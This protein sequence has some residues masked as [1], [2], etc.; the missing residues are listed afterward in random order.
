MSP[1]PAKSATKLDGAK[2]QN[3]TIKHSKPPLEQV[4]LEWADFLYREFK[5]M[6]QL[7]CYN[8]DNMVKPTA[9]AKS[10]S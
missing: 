10:K 2:L 7:D 6:Q 3:Q 5:R 9:H 1:K 4:A 8:N